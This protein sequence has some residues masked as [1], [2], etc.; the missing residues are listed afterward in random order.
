MLAAIGSLAT[1]LAAAQAGPRAYALVGNTLLPFDV[2]HPQL[3]GAPIP[4]TGMFDGE[5]MVGID[6]R[7]INGHLYGI[8]ISQAGGS[9]QLYH[10]GLQTGAAASPSTGSPVLGSRR[11]LCP[12]SLTTR[13]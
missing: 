5:I 12:A 11:K 6:I 10:I 13:S 4:I 1:G 3:V 8:A 9:V 2:E 7:P